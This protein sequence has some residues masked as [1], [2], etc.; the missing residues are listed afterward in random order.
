MHGKNVNQGLINKAWYL[1]HLEIGITP[2]GVDLDVLG[3]LQVGHSIVQIWICIWTVL[4][5]VMEKYESLT[6]Q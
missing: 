4:E 3:I 2:F 1:E 6:I 5:S